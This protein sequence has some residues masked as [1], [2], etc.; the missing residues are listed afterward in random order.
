METEGETQVELRRKCGKLSKM[1]NLIEELK[2]KSAFPLTL[3][4]RVT[5][6][7]HFGKLVLG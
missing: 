7:I 1:E 4:F 2:K 3:Q 5:N 6:S